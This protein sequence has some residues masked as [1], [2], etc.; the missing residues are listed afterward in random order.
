MGSSILLCSQ[1][2]DEGMYLKR[3]AASWAGDLQ[4]QDVRVR[5]AAAYALGKMNKHALPYINSL[6]KVLLQDTD[7]RVRVSV[8]DTLGELGSLAIGEVT[9]GLKQSLEKEKEAG[10]QRAVILALGK[11]GQQAASTEAQ[12]R[13]FL[14]HSDVSLRK[15]AAWTLGQLGPVAERSIPALIKAIS[16]GGASVRAEAISS[17]GNLGILAQDAIPAMVIGR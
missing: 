14:S 6:N 13:A 8:A 7:A 16:D 11:Q 15:N 12:I 9:A 17:L 1:T 3:N 4:H 2:S 10:V 5:R